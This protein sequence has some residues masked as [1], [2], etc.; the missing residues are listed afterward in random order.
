MTGKWWINWGQEDLNFKSKEQKDW[1]RL[2]VAGPAPPFS[3]DSW[4]TSHL[5]TSHSVHGWCLKST[6]QINLVSVIP[7]FFP[8]AL[9]GSTSLGGEERMHVWGR[10]GRRKGVYNFKS[11]PVQSSQPKAKKLRAVQLIGRGDEIHAV[12]SAHFL[13]ARCLCGE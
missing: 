2:A 4:A 7:F 5:Q 11:D 3:S 6:F 10:E 1:L 13:V 12:V 9:C 8:A